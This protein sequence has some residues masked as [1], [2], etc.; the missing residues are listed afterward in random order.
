MVNKIWFHADDYGL[1]KIQ[2]EKILECYKEGVLN[3]ISIIPNSNKLSEA[4]EVLNGIDCNNEIRRVLHLNFVE[5][6]PLSDLKEVPMLI[7][8]DGYFDKSFIHYFKWNLVKS[9]S[10]KKILSQQLKIEIRNQLRAVTKTNDFKI[11]AID[12]HQHYHMIPI[13]FDNLM[14]VLSEQ[15]FKSIKISN[16]RISVDPLIP[17]FSD[18]RL[19]RKVPIINWVKWSILK[20]YANRNRKILKDKGISAP[21]FCGIF[22]TCQMKLEI[23]K[24]LLPLYKCY[25]DKKKMELEL[26][27]HPGGLVNKQE[28]LDVRNVELEEFYFSDNRRYE[29]ECLRSISET[30]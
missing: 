21:I 30:E 7:D 20:L 10:Q 25:A 22:F 28:M 15:E 14:E 13:I 4:Y 17:L 12:S 18:L 19:L 24:R 5:G 16:I 1:T 26:M 2:S 6:R 27:F 23:V 11:T 8:E 29:S 3:S 9:K